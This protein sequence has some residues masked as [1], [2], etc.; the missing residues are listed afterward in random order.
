MYR[1]VIRD[2]LIY[3]VAS[4]LTRGLAI[5]LLPI[6]TRVLST[7]EYGAYDLII[8]LGVLANVTVALEVTQGY[9]RLQADVNEERRKEL[10]STALLFVLVMYLVFLSLCLYFDETL[11][12]LLLG[13][14]EFISAFRWGMLFVAA[15]GI[16]MFMLNQLRWDLKSRQYAL[17]SLLY[18]LT[19]LLVSSF[20]CLVMGYGLKGV[21]IAQFSAAVIGALCCLYFSYG[22]YLAGR[23]LGLLRD[24]LRFSIP[25]VP[26]SLA[27]FINLYASRI[28][29]KHFSSLDDVGLYA[30]A[31]R[32]GGAS[33]LMVVGVQAALTPLIYRQ[34]QSPETPGRIATLFHG[35]LA[36]ALPG[37]LV[38]SVFAEEIIAIFSTH[39]FHEA[40]PLVSILAPAM[41]ASQ[42]YVFAPG[43]AIRKKTHWQL[44]VTIAAAG[45]SIAGNLILVPL[46]GAYGAAITLVL[47]TAAF[48]VIWVLFSQSFYH[49]PFQW[50]RVL[51][52][53]GVYTLLAFW[54]S[55]LGYGEWSLI[56]VM[57]IKLLLVL[58]M[59]AAVLVCGFIDKKYLGVLIR[60]FRGFT[61]EK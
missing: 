43:I 26:A 53:V 30:I 8:S 23:S 45:V 29:L 16:Y 11:T 27:V 32:L 4:L 5:L 14:A 39:E 52:C 24:M 40:A 50:G 54:G 6:Y 34:Y 3:G 37:C 46:Y 41:L 28:A 22:N 9:A 58:G 12:R 18:A 31:S 25:L 35:F 57:G 59:I 60:K 17:A 1:G 7:S 10:G 42:L 47:S 44:L 38:L 20:L 36:I 56:V 13:D 19:T 15:N 2:S 61:S 33:L 48:L 55:R 51:V 21:V 49:V